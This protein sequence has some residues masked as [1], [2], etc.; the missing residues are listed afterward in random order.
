MQERLTVVTRKG[1]IT[2]PIEVRRALGIKEGDKIAISL[3]VEGDGQATLRPIRS[4]AEMTF[5]V[6][7]PRKRPENMRE[8]R[9]AFMDDIAERELSRVSPVSESGGTSSKE[10]ARQ[11]SGVQ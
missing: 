6:F 10:G 3:P 7:E 1:Q 8:L 9:E 5:G 2:I 11:E 4:V